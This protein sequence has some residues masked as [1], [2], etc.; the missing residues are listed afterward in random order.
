M[1]AVTIRISARAGATVILLLAC[2]FIASALSTVA[3]EPRTVIVFGDSITEGG[4]LP[5]S[6]RTNTWV[7]VVERESKGSLAMVNEGKGGRP[8]ASLKEF[9]AMLAR[10]AKADVLVLALGT[11]DSRDITDDCVPKAVANL[12]AMI[13]K[14]RATYG[15]KLRVL[16]VGPPNINKS[17]L[18]PTKPIANEREAKLVE[19]GAAFAKLAKEL[20]CDFVSLFGVVPESTLLKDG[21]HPDVA[22]NAAIART[23]LPKLSP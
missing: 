23:I 1:S 8:T 10:R 22:G 11:N 20:N 13:T 17:A 5:K 14:A 21:V 9:D 2:S 7:Y 18:G 6:E 4:A 16:L 3:A 15:A 19:Q 12:R